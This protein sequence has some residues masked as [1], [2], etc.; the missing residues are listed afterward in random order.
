MIMIFYTL[1]LDLVIVS[2]RNRLKEELNFELLINQFKILGNYKKF[3]MSFQDLHLL[4]V[5]KL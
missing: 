2:F 4:L 1:L 5:N 3:A